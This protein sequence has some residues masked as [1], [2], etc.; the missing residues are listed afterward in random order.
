MPDAS[1]P[2]G[3]HGK[4]ALVIGA[5]LGIGLGIA[6]RLAGVDISSVHEELPFPGF[7]Q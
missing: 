3:L 1:D 5:M 2:P 7:E 6:R 4:V